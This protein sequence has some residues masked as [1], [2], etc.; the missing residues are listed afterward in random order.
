M[1]DVALNALGSRGVGKEG[2][3]YRWT[4]WLRTE[5]RW[6]FQPLR[7]A[8]TAS[9]KA[10]PPVPS[11]AYGLNDPMELITGHSECLSAYG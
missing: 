9:P 8:I 2:S 6:S 3:F 10:A 4:S 1:S 7:A 5:D 11:I